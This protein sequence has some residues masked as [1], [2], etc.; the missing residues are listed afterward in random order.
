MQ[1]IIKTLIAI[2]FG[3]TASQ[4]EREVYFKALKKLHDEVGM[5]AITKVAQGLTPMGKIVRKL[6]GGELK[7]SWLKPLPDGELG[8]AMRGVPPMTPP[9]R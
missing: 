2:A 3:V 9:R 1:G 8:S 5:E 7:D 6:N 4:V